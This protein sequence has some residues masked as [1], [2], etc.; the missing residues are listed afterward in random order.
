MSSKKCLLENLPAKRFSK[1]FTGTR[2]KSKD[3]DFHGCR[4]VRDNETVLRMYKSQI[5][6]GRCNMKKTFVISAATFIAIGAAIFS[7][8]EANA[9]DARGGGVN[10]I[11]LAPVP[12]NDAMSKAPRRPHRHGVVGRSIYVNGA[13]MKYSPPR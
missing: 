5:A 8:S 11:R 7:W 10:I 9:E 13:H 12:P 1:A 6:L 3:A 4:Y 2:R